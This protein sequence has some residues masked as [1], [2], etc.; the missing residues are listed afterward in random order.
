MHRAQPGRLGIGCLVNV[1][2]GGGRAGAVQLSTFGSF[3]MQSEARNNLTEGGAGAGVPGSGGR[4]TKV[5]AGGLPGGGPC[6]AS[7]EGLESRVPG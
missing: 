7:A 4:N 6:Q 3:K 2:L 5:L 1:P